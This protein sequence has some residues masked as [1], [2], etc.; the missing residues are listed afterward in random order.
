MFTGIIE[1]IGSVENV[2][3]SGSNLDLLIRSQIS[4]ELKI[5]QSIA[6]NGVCL[7]VVAQQDDQHTVTI[8]KESLQ[9]S[10]LSHLEK[11]TP[12]NLE[13]CLKLGDRLDGHLVQGHV[14]ETVPCLDISNQNGSWHYR[15][16][17]PDDPSLIV[18]KGSIT[19]NGV[20]L[21]V[22]D[23]DDE[24]FRVAV[25]PYTHEHTTF[26]QLGVNDRVNLEYDMLGK[27][28]QRL[29]IA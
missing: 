11:G 7:T 18:R 15:F 19:L 5:D 6:H 24:S 27:Y 28:V 9:R 14:D 10:N 4:S 26:R 20:S 12:V 22:A 17:L 29:L 16:R 3:R 1:C 23:L 21:T 25:I 13:R 2:T 8:V